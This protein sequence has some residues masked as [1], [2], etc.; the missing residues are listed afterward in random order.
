MVGG[1]SHRVPL[2]NISA[3]TI[4]PG[5]NFKTPFHGGVRPRLRLERL[6][7]SN[8]L[9]LINRLGERLP[10]FQAA[11]ARSRKN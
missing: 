3:I 6:D 5:G 4:E 1:R 11:V 8:E 10:L 7:G 9:L 2:S